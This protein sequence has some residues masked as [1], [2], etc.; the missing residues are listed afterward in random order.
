[1]MLQ[2]CS[3]YCGHN[4]YVTKYI[5]LYNN[6]VSVEELKRHSSILKVNVHVDVLSPFEPVLYIIL[7]SHLVS[8]SG[9]WVD[10]WVL[11]L[12]IQEIN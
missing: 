8:H 5:L 7:K 1:M 2:K 11:V 3:T 12:G 10:N 4:N 9:Q 6:N